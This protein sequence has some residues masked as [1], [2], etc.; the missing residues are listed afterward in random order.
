M[1]LTEQKTIL[2]AIMYIFSLKDYYSYNHSE[3][4]ANL[5]QHIG[6][7]LK[8]SEEC[9]DILYWGGMVHDI[10][11]MVLPLEL[12]I[13]PGTISFE[14]LSLLKRHAVIGHQI[15]SKINW[16][17]PLAAIAI[18]HHERLNGTGYPFGLYDNDI[19]LESKII[20]VAD[21]VD[22]MST[23]RPY[24]QAHSIQH[25]INYLQNNAGETLHEDSCII[26]IEWLSQCK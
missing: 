11:K 10:G 25:T 9:L 1:N 22:A 23:N 18:Q 13:K 14:E 24:R 6:K 19:I 5:A 4:V 8:L 3:N 26:A 15:L 21:I 20:A 7:E 17:Y 12:L 16:S 2:E